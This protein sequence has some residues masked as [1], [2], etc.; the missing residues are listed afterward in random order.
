[1]RVAVNERWRR[2]A[3]GWRTPAEAWASRP[4]L[5]RDLRDSFRNEMYDRAARIERH[6]DHVTRCSRYPT[7]RRAYTTTGNML[8]TTSTAADVSSAGYCIQGSTAHFMDVSMSM[9]MGTM[10]QVV[11]NTDLVGEKQ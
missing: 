3:L 6:M 8:T 7:R 5:E 4:R 1:M 10:G 9:N 11:I 2:R